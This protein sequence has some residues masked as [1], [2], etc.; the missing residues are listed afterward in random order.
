[1]SFRDI[2][3]EALKKKAQKTHENNFCRGP[4][5][6]VVDSV[7]TTLRRGVHVVVRKFVLDPVKGEHRQ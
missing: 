2:K 1:M 3:S 4:F 7:S 5:K 6:A